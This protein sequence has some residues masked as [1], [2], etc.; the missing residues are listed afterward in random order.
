MGP[1][2]FAAGLFGGFRLGN[3]LYAD[4]DG[5]GAETELFVLD[6]GETGVPHQVQ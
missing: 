3:R 6:S 2:A 4:V 5:D 1:V